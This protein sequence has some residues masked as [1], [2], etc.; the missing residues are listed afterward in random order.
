MG[1]TRDIGQY[2]DVR[3]MLDAI[4]ATRGGI[5]TLNTRAEAI[6]WR[7]RAYMLRT[8]LTE[9]D[10]AGT[11]Y[12]SMVMRNPVESPD[13]WSITVECER[14]SSARL[15]DLNGNPLTIAP[16]QPA[17]SPAEAWTRSDFDALEYKL[18]HEQG[19]FVDKPKRKRTRK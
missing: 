16:P 5:V 6:S 14:R 11:P 10:K 3:D 2:I 18:H 15:F 9:T 13:G 7:Q 8:L 1:M 19:D 17:I 4:L 12:D